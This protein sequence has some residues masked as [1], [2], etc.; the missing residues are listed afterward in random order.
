VQVRKT[1]RPYSGLTYFYNHSVAAYHSHITKSHGEFLSNAADCQKTGATSRLLGYVVSPSESAAYLKTFG[2]SLDP[3]VSCATY[4]TA[5]K[6]TFGAKD[7]ELDSEVCSQVVFAGLSTG[8]TIQQTA[9]QT[10]ADRYT[11]PLRSIRM[12]SIRGS[13]TSLFSTNYETVFGGQMD[14]D[15][16]IAG[17]NS[18]FSFS[19]TSGYNPSYSAPTAKCAIDAT[20]DPAAAASLTATPVTAAGACVLSNLVAKLA[21][22][23]GPIVVK[24]A[25]GPSP[26]K[27]VPAPVP[28]PA[29]AP[30]AVKPA[31]APAPAPVAVK[32]AQPAPAPRPVLNRACRNCAI[33]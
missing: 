2:G 20:F 32:P 17:L 28:A 10:D 13:W 16:A 27:P 22:L 7:Y 5:T 33:P 15:Y 3:I 21:K 24:A 11:F 25:P 1:V 26:L 9:S 14:W 6:S 30:V 8:F 23:E 18:T 4:G 19:N 12:Q 31:P 29:P